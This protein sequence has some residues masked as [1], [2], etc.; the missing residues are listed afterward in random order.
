MPDTGKPTFQE[1]STKPKTMAHTFDVS[2]IQDTLGKI[3]SDDVIGDMA[4]MRQYMAVEHK[5]HINSALLD[6]VTDKEYV[7]GSTAYNF[8]SIDRVVSSYDEVT[9][10]G[11]VDANDAD[12]YG[13]DRDASASWADAYVSHNSNSDRDLTDSLLRTLKQ[14]VLTN[15]QN[16]LPVLPLS[17]TLFNICKMLGF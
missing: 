11:D 9:N 14:N 10:C 3:K 7:D 6:D 4:F 1:V 2:E 16:N 13:I 12:I 17:Y 5:E 8:E 15:R